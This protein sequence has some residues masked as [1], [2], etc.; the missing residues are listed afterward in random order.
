MKNIFYAWQI[1]IISQYTFKALL[2]GNNVYSAVVHVV[3]A[4]CD[5]SVKYFSRG[6]I[7]TN[8]LNTMFV[9]M[10]YLFFRWKTIRS[11]PKRNKSCTY[12][13][14]LYIQ[15]PISRMQMKNTFNSR[16]PE[17]VFRWIEIVFF[18][19]LSLALYLSLYLSFSLSIYFS[20]IYL[21]IFNFILWNI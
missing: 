17:F 4:S 21:F 11:S 15:K 2:F 5:I 13:Y 3:A 16:T 19:F 10:I 14:I 8:L 9:T 6:T 20:L 12:I 1:V 7:Y 18:H